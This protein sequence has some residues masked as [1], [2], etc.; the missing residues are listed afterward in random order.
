MLA[1]R[2]VGTLTEIATFSFYPTKNLGAM[3]DGGAVVTNDAALAA[4]VRRLRNGGQASRYDHVEAGVNSRLDEMQAAILRVRLAGLADATGVRRRLAAAYRERLVPR[5]GAVA[6][7]D[8]GHVYHLFPIRS[9]AR[10]ALQAS[11]GARGMETLVHY[12]VPLSNQPA[13]ARFHPGACPVAGQAGRELLSLPLHPRLAVSEALAV[14]DAV[15]EFVER[16][17]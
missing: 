8:A 16:T 10:D 7:H 11:L 3:G 13:F 4:R 6:E 15:N 17:S 2:K 9:S 12:P 1:G 5:A 14:A